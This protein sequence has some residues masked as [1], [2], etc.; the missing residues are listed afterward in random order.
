MPPYHRLQRDEAAFEIDPAKVD[1]TD[2]DD[3]VSAFPAVAGD[4]V[5]SHHVRR[6]A[7]LAGCGTLR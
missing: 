3:K 2:H 4:I 6:R 7:V 1:G 5:S